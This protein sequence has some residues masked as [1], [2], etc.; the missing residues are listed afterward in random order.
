V[1]GVLLVAVSVAF[2][3]TLHIGTLTFCSPPTSTGSYSTSTQ[4]SKITGSGTAQTGL[5]KVKKDGSSTVSVKVSGFYAKNYS[6]NF[7]IPGSTSNCHRGAT[8][9]GQVRSLLG[10]NS[11]GKPNTAAG[12]AFAVGIGTSPYPV[13]QTPATLSTGS[14][15]ICVQDEPNVVDGNMLNVSVI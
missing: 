9:T 6:I 7:R 3:C 14:A 1:T 13:V 5:A 4:C 15:Q 8:A 2:A 10:F 12:P 11:L